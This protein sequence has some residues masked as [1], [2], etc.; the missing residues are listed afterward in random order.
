MLH[1]SCDL[2]SAA[3]TVATVFGNK[4]LEAGCPVMSLNT[5]VAALVAQWAGGGV[6]L[7]VH[8][9]VDTRV[10]T[11]LLILFALLVFVL[12]PMLTGTRVWLVM[13]VVGLAIH[14]DI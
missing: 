6:T 1:T 14:V 11:S 3:H 9:T 13:L 5:L 8:H 4:L 12:V 10:G 7:G 2:R